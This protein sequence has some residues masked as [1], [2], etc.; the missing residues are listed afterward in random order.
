MEAT[1]VLIDGW[2]DKQNIV[3]T[4]NAVLFSLKMEVNSNICYNMDISWGHYLKLRD[5]FWSPKDK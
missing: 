1:Q 4:Y 5:L 3:H 2:N